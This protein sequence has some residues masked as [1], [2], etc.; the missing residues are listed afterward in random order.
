MKACA[1]MTAA[2]YEETVAA[3]RAKR[4]RFPVSPKGGRTWDGIVFASKREMHRYIALKE[5]EAHGGISR[6]ELQPAFPVLIK[7]QRFCTYHADF[8]YVENGVVVI[9]DVK[10]SGT[11]KDQAFRLRKKAAEIYYGIKIVE[12]SK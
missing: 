5:R 1:R 4:G 8:S 7:G 9:E 11:A 2:E 3:L 10:S 6:L 12:I